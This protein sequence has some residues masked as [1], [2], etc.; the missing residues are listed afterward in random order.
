MEKLSLYE[1]LSFVLPGAVMLEVINRFS[2]HILEQ[3]KEGLIPSGSFGEGLIFL[4]LALFVGSIIHIVSFKLSM[5][6]E[7]YNTLAAKP[8]NKMKNANYIEKIYP[9]LQEEFCRKH[10]LTDKN[11]SKVDIFDTAYYYL[12]ANDKITQAKNFQSL[13]FLFRNMF[14]VC[15]VVFVFSSLGIIVFLIIGECDKATC[16]AY[17]YLTTLICGFLS[18]FV[19]Q[20]F[21]VKMTDRILGLYYSELTHK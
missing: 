15:M 7:W 2:S 6:Y 11:V 5:K 3:E 13:F 10:S 20:W 21:R 4:S 12:E 1:L 8:I 14:T 9:K 16:L 19:A 17:Y 18:S